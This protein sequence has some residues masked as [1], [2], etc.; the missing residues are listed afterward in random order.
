MGAGPRHIDHGHAVRGRPNTARD[1]AKCMASQP[2]SQPSMVQGLQIST[3]TGGPA[4]TPEQRRFNTLIRQIDQARRTL[5]AWQEHTLHYAQAYTRLIVPLAKELA[6]EQRLWCFALDRLLGQPDWSRSESATL[7]ELL[8]D[9]AADLLSDGN[10]DAPD[11]A[12][13]A[14]F[15][16]HA[17]VDFD[18]EQ[19]QSRLAL[20]DMVETMTGID[21][22][23]DDIASEQ[24]LF[25][26]M[27]QQ[28]ADDEAPAEEVPRRKSKAQQRREAEAQLATQSVREVFRKLASALHPDRETDAAARESK[29]ALMQKANQA[30]AANDLLALLELQLQVEQVDAG[31]IGS[32][33]AQRVRHYN[34][35]LAEQLEELKDEID[36]VEIGFRMDFGL[37]PGLGLNPKKLLGS[38]EAQA[39]DMRAGLALRRQELRKLDDRVGMKRW[40]KR[41]RQRLREPT[42]DDDFF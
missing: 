9:A 39:K 5:A 3:R 36:R 23:D 8:C 22:G 41:Q 19:Q 16:L 18:T 15:D 37:E 29:T 6:A 42:F 1:T 7:R 4:L 12:L 20:K 38:I 17:D 24:D 35:V 14:L 33:S 10:E 26:R 2:N 34:K 32:A 31:H 25:K 21:L 30:Y 27:R 28:L 11:A 40:L 13:K